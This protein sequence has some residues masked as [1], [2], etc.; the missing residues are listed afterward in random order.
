VKESHLFFRKIGGFLEN[1]S[2]PFTS[3]T[4]I[5]RGSLIF[6]RAI[7]TRI[8]RNPHALMERI[9]PVATPHLRGV[10]AK[11]VLNGRLREFL[12]KYSTPVKQRA[13]PRE[14]QIAPDRNVPEKSGK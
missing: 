5:E 6:D 4:Y 12:G 13:S 9:N 2:N 14:R 10:R 7:A 8:E 1:T 3:V 11:R